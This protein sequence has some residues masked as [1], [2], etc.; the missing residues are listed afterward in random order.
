MK[1][2]LL[3]YKWFC[4]F[5][6]GRKISLQADVKCNKINKLLFKEIILKRLRYIKAHL[7]NMK[8]PACRRLPLKRGFKRQES[9]PPAVSN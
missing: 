5:K 6:Q 2:F 7:E 4:L 8:N 1:I 3:V 9:V